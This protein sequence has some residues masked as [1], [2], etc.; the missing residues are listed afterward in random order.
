MKLKLEQL[1][2]ENLLEKNLR[3]VPVSDTESPAFTQSAYY[4]LILLMQRA[5]TNFTWMQNTLK[6]VENLH[7]DMEQMHHAAF[8]L[9][10]SGPVLGLL[11]RYHQPPGW[12]AVTNRQAF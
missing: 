8:R 6:V 3:L 7:F 11:D 2:M 9:L 4:I 5:R 10:Q 1:K 12:I